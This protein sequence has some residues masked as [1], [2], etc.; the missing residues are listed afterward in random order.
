MDEHPSLPRASFQTLCNFLP[1]SGEFELLP[2]TPPGHK[3]ASVSTVIPEDCNR[4]FTKHLLCPSPCPA[5]IR[6]NRSAQ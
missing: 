5:R 3:T 6:Y 1:T 2:V 4:V